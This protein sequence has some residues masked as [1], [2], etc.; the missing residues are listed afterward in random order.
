MAEHGAGDSDQPEQQPRLHHLLPLS[1]AGGASVHSATEHYVLLEERGKSPTASAGKAAGM[2]EPAESTQKSHAGTGAITL[3]ALSGVRG[4]A[5]VAIVLGHFFTFFCPRFGTD[6]AF[7]VLTPEY[8]SGVTLFIIISGF[9]LTVVY[10]KDAKGGPQAPPPL[11]TWPQLKQFLRKRV[12]RLLPVYYLGL[13]AGLAPL[14]VY[15]DTYVIATS[16][17]IALLALQSLTCI[18]GVLWDPP[19][20]TVSAFIFCYLCFPVLLRWLRERSTRQLTAVLVACFVASS[21]L[22]SVWLPL[23]GLAES[24]SFLH[25]FAGFRLLH[26][27]IGVATA[28]LAKRVPCP[29]P[30]LVAEACALLLAANQVACLAGT[31]HNF[32]RWFWYQYFAEFLLPPVHAAWLWALTSPGCAGPS[33]TV[34]ASAP[35][36]LLGDVSYSLY[37]LHWPTLIWSAWAFEGRGISRAA[38]PEYANGWYVYPAWAFL[39]ALAVCLVVAAGAYLLGR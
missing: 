5:A 31:A 10:D 22:P 1:M 13:A 39:P 19:L 32:T 36:S 16:V 24:T 20:W 8:L 25:S 11:S 34:L 23:T 7:P 27:T 28:L 35:L 33:R 4:L 3:N 17:P 9:T 29:R 14:I 37:A 21:V 12:A 38:V 6:V 18:V 26:F 2:G 15:A 30:T